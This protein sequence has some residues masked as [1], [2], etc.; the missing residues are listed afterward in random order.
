M[1]S[2]RKRVVLVGA[3]A[4]VL[5]GVGIGYSLYAVARSGDGAHAAGDVVP[6]TDHGLYVRD[7]EGSVVLQDGGGAPGRTGTGLECNR[8]YAAGDT[9]VCV[10][11]EGSL[12]PTTKVEVLDADLTPT[13]TFTYSG[14]P[15]RARVSPSGRMVAWTVFVTGDNYAGTNFSTRTGIYDRDTGRIVDSLEGIPLYIDGERVHRVDVNYWGVT[16]AEDDDTFYA[17]VSTAGT[18]YLVEG[19]VSEWSATA[20]RENVEC[21]SLSP[22]GTR[23]VFKKRV[24]DSV[25]DPW[26]LYVLDLA[27]MQETPLAE[28]RSVDDQAAWIDDDTVAYGV[29]GGVWSVSA[30][31]AGQPELIA[32][33]ASSP[34]MVH[35]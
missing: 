18:T 3:A 9:A 7:S 16:F 19:D 29:D 34:A 24:N 20:L 12:K 25:D 2:M 32:E 5:A 8:F 33:D 17:T 21:P 6:A 14:V 27:T 22:D 31:G 13:E 23:I 1:T 10:S 35:D 4:L 26:R 11:V 30:D 28:D 15:T